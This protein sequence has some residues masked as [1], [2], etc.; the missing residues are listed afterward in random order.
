MK[1]ALVR[2]ISDQ[3]DRAIVRFSADRPPHVE[4][5][6]AQHAAYVTSLQALGLEAHWLPSSTSP[7][8]C[9]VEDQAVVVGRTALITRSG[10]P[11][12]RGEADEVA[13]ALAQTHRVVRM[14]DPATLDGGDVLR[15]GNTLFVGVSERT[16]T[17]GVSFLA[18]TFRPLGFQ[19]KEV[20]VKDALHLKCHA[21]ALDE[22]TVLLAPSMVSPS[23][24]PGMQ[25]VE[26]S[27]AEAYA[28]NVV[29][30]GKR[31]LVAAGY[32][33]VV[34]SL[35]SRGFQVTVL[36]VDEFARADGSLTC[37]SVLW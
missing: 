29:T 16:S 25:I 11:A 32:P 20:A 1:H 34:D 6:R 7:D 19:V 8:G 22:Q 26:V 12:R 9:F 27:A 37:L 4:R 31:A 2:P 10:H 15:L 14:E 23:S 35:T 17:L 18:A 3:F 24:F 28:A 5:A 33:G 21:T 36:E 13:S 30:V